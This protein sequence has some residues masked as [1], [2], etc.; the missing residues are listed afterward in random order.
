VFEQA[1][2]FYLSQGF[3]QS[4]L[5]AMTLMMTL[6]TVWEILAETD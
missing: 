2:Q 6:E 3:V 1:K 4:P 5:Q